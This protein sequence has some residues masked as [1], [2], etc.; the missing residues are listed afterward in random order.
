MVV[1]ESQEGTPAKLQ[2]SSYASPRP[3][4]KS[5]QFGRFHAE[6][7]S[8]QLLYPLPSPPSSPMAV[9]WSPAALFFTLIH[10]YTALLAL[11]A[12]EPFDCHPT[13]GPAKYDLTSL[14]GEHT[15]SRTR[16]MPPSSMED[17]VT[18]DLCAEIQKKDGVPDVDQ[19]RRWR[20]GCIPQSYGSSF[21]FSVQAVPSSA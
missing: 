16:E 12:D 15:I 1:V 5:A 21:H 10:L 9:R 8:F 14:K 4:G 19:V 13:I 17:I 18:F 20:L 3:R 7:P 6:P 11:A 2:P